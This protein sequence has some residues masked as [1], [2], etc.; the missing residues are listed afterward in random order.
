MVKRSK[1]IRLEDVPWRRVEDSRDW[2]RHKRL[3]WEETGSKEL[4]VG[5]GE[6]DPGR[7]LGL[8]H[9]ENIAEFYYAISGRAKVTVEDEEIDAREGTAIYI[10]PSAKHKIVNDGEEKFVFIYGLNASS[11]PYVWDEPSEK[12]GSN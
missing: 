10:P 7:W 12:Y 2:L 4:C 1:A 3:I 11:R 5:L 6:L 8:H 9:H